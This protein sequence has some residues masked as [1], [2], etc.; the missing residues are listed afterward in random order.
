MEMKEKMERRVE[1]KKDVDEEELRLRDQTLS[2]TPGD[3]DSPKRET[4]IY[5]PE[6]EGKGMVPTSS[7]EQQNV[8]EKREEA[9]K[10][11]KSTDLGGR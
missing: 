9:A 5:A 3:T 6:G 2:R 11:I 4:G 8:G 7:E 10:R 1:E